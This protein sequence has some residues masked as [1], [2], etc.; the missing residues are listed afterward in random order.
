MT[1]MCPHEKRYKGWCVD[2]GVR[3]LASAKTA[4][5]PWEQEIELVPLGMKS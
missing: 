1:S 5:H 4:D 3:L 2:C